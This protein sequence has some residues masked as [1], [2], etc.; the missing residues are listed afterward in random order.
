ML[1]SQSK[2]CNSFQV[3]LS[4]TLQQFGISNKGLESLRNLGIAAH[5]RTVKILTRSSFSSHN[6]HVFTFIKAAIENNQ[7]LI[8][9]IDDYHNIHTHHRPETKTQK[10]AIHT[11]T[12]LLKVFP[13]IEAVPQHGNNVLPTPPVK[14]H[15][16]KNYVASNLSSLSKMHAENMPDWVLVKYF[17]PEAE[18]QRLLVH[19]YQQTEN[20]QMR[21]MDNTK[22]VD[23]IKLPLK[24]CEDALVAINKMLTSGLD[25]YLNH[26]V[27]I[28]LVIGQCSF[29]F[30]SWS[31]PMP[32][33]YLKS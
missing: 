6:S 19:D 24:S 13:E 5:P 22:L 28:F 4:R 26:Y 9:C 32:H 8:F 23:S 17:N 21:S 10:Q 1:Y 11:A 30:D 31:I 15:D 27:C 18:R 2:K 12:L 25:I 33:R 14:I 20:Q 3:A 7:F 16:V 29:S